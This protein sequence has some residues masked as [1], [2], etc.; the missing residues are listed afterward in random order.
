M[1]P[2]RESFPNDKLNPE[3]TLLLANVEK[4]S[5]EKGRVAKNLNQ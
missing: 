4:K 1:E 2:R 3:Y 5:E